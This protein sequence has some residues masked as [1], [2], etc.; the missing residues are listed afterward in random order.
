M[1]SAA[2]LV[3][4]VIL[5]VVNLGVLVQGFLARASDAGRPSDAGI[6]IGLD[7]VE[8]EAVASTLD[9]PRATRYLS[10][11]YTAE[12]VLDCTDGVRGVVA[13]RLA[14][15]FAAKE[16]AMKAL[17]VGGRAVPWNAIE[18]VRR[19]DGQPTLALRGE[20]AAIARSLGMSRFS[21]SVSHEEQYAVALVVLS[22]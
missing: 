9:S 14:G 19:P 22:A 11:I 1:V 16:A 2:V 6:R 12:E 8:V 17:G 5:C 15:R 4:A 18:V 7:L 13:H 3:V 10:R 21:V 20:A